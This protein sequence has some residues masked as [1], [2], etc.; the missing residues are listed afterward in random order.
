[1]TDI[2]QAASDKETNKMQNQSLYGLR[3]DISVCWKLK[4]K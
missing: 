4:E 3:S 2:V 1:M